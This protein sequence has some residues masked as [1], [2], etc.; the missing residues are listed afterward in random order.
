[1]LATM[2]KR[3][4]AS[5]L[6]GRPL[7]LLDALANAYDRTQRLAITHAYWRLTSLLAEH[8]LCAAEHEHLRQLQV[9]PNDT[10]LLRTAQVSAEASLRAA[11]VAVV[12]AQ[13]DLAEAAGL[14]SQ[15]SLP[16][17]VDLPH[18]GPYRTNFEIVAAR[19][20]LPPRSRL[21]DR[22]LPI[23][24]QSIDVWASAVQAAED[25][26]Q[27]INEAYQEGATDLA[28]V[29]EYTAL[30]GR[31]QRSFMTSVCD[32]N[33]DIAD[34]AIAVAGPEIV[35]PALVAML[36]KTNHQTSPRSAPAGS[37][38]QNPLRGNMGTSAPLDTGVQPATLNMPV[39]DELL[40]TLQPRPNQPTLAPPRDRL[41]PTGHNMPTL[42]P[43][44]DQFK[45]SGVGLP[46]LA[47]PRDK[48]MP[49]SPE[50]PTLAPPQQPPASTAVDPPVTK[51]SASPPQPAPVDDEP[52][53]PPVPTKDSAPSETPTSLVPVSPSESSMIHRTSYKTPL[54]NATNGLATTGLYPGLVDATSSVRAKRLT[55]TLFNT[56]TS[57]FAT[58]RAIELRDCLR[59]TRTGDRLELIEAYWRAQQR[60]AEYQALAMHNDWLAE[61]LPFT[62]GRR[63]EPGGPG[64]MLRLRAA[65][66]AV[67]ARLL[68]AQLQF[69]AAQFDLTERAGLP[70]SSAWLRP[71]TAPHAGPYLLRLEAQPPQLGAALPVRRLAATIPALNV[72]LQDRAN[73][74]IQADQTRAAATTA[75]QNGR[76]TLDYAL[77]T[78][79]LQTSETRA[80]LG[81]VTEYN[82][83]I[84]NYVLIVTPP[85]V[86]SDKLVEALVTTK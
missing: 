54:D 79:N 20:V 13:Y 69:L 34:Y 81:T 8:S 24:R 61:F 21:I 10:T 75:Y 60:A 6:E 14:P 56:Q 33:H 62:L 46:T 23:R 44:R 29:L 12:A 58:G 65:Q 67:K 27:A 25:A 18:V 72:N 73:S 42:A 47:T 39:P 50:H 76:C 26:A 19:Q 84:S 85:S 15:E 80:F 30:L 53:T 64:E 22:M 78:L 86:P 83:A 7:T 1:M 74:V 49:Q 82:L 70:T 41:A 11:E 43:P 36:I 5:K 63:N 38:G 57:S 16:L 35:G 55:Q 66:L 71:Q 37:G 31:R 45:S 2:L 68:E 48:L 51:E 40:N 9:R 77:T 4:S 17:P 59:E 32:Y 28:T 3:S 52:A